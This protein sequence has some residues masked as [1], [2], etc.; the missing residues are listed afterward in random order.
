MATPTSNRSITVNNFADIGRPEV[1]ENVIW[2]VQEGESM[3]VAYENPTSRAKSVKDARRRE[4]CV[5]VYN[6][7]SVYPKSIKP[8]QIDYVERSL[9]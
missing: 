4:Q 7:V 5:K 2:V 9:S 3:T 8:G 6:L 1:P